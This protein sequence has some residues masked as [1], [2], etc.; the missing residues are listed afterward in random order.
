MYFNVDCFVSDC[1][2]VW[3]GVGDFVAFVVVVSVCSF[4]TFLTSRHPSGSGVSSP[5]V[6]SL[7]FLARVYRFL[8]ILCYLAFRA[9]MMMM[10]CEGRS[11]GCNSLFKSLF[12]HTKSLLASCA[13]V[14]QERGIYVCVCAFN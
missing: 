8:T 12:Q 1:A 3:E 14:D 9:Q 5:A 10:G 4:A 13:P 11:V 6:F 2:G 7:I